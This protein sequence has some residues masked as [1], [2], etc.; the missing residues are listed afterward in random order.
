LPRSALSTT[1]LGL[2]LA[3]VVP[4][5]LLSLLVALLLRPDPRSAWDQAGL[6]RGLPE[7]NTP[8]QRGLWSD[9]MR[10]VLAEADRLGPP[11]A[12]P[13]QRRPWLEA[14]CGLNRRLQALQRQFGRPVET[15]AAMGRPPACEQLARR[16]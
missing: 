8:D 2:G 7:A 13:A 6:T 10:A 16:D 15:A 5:L 11:P 1:P 9:Q 12:A 4:L 3:L 14:Q